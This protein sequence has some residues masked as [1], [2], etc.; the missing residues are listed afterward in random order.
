MTKE[1]RIDRLNE[2]YDALEVVDKALGEVL[3]LHTRG[4]DQYSAKRW[5]KITRKSLRTLLVQVGTDAW[6]RILEGE[7]AS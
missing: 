4:I 3:D 1:E 2:L 5:A 6:Y 7:R